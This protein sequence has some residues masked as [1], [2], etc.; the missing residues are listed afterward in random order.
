MGMNG[1][2]INLVTT[3]NVK[4]WELYAKEFVQSFNE[5]W[6][7]QVQLAVYYDGGDLPDDVIE[8][9]RISYF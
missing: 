8:S 3:F 6:D 2:N 9:P 5:N 1:M 4:A 7:E